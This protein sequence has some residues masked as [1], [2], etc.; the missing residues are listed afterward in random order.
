M[1]GT[2]LNQQVF[3]RR[4]P[5]LTIAHMRAPLPQVKEKNQDRRKSDNPGRHLRSK[6]DIRKR[7]IIASGLFFLLFGLLMIGGKIVEGYPVS[8]G[9]TL[10][11]ESDL[12]QAYYEAIISDQIR[13]T[14]EYSAGQDRIAT[15]SMKQYTVKKNDTLSGIA[16]GFGVTIDTIISYNKIKS[17][18]RVLEGMT[19]LI[20]NKSGIPHTVRS[21]ENLSRIA[22]KY[23]VALEDILDW[24]NIAS[25]I[26]KPGEVLFI[27]GAGMNTYEL[28]KVLGTLFVFPARGRISSRYGNRIHPISGKRHF[29]NGID[30]A[31]SGGTPVRAALDGRVQK[32]GYSNV[33]GKYVII[34]HA[35]GLQTFYGHL[36]K[37]T[38][39]KGDMVNQGGIL[40]EM[41]NTGYSTGNHLHFSIYKNGDTVDPL[42]YLK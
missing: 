22:E 2:L 18:F 23:N 6:K 3:R 1:I 34:K 42:F 24:N 26:I 27:P 15:L 38:V 29:H 31:N 11:A 10:P 9:I 28:R 14:Y 8:A 33:Y 35:M 41:G 4:Q 12:G 17:V 20:P 21:G 39:V 25:S 40:G 32:T 5:F 36:R 37:I 30:I 19:L 16:A 13:E 7:I